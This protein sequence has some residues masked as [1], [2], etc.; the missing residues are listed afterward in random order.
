MNEPKHFA[1]GARVRVPAEAGWRTDFVGTITAR[2]PRQVTTTTGDDWFYWVD[3][4]EGQY[5]VDGDGPYVDAE[6]LS[7]YLSPL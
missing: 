7:S 4:D 1:V 6:I 3:F 5:D 2:P